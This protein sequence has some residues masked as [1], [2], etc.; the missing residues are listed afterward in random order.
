MSGIL[1]DDRV[2]CIVPK[3]CSPTP[4]RSNCR[5]VVH[6]TLYEPLEL[7]L[8]RNPEI[9]EIVQVLGGMSTTDLLSNGV[10]RAGGVFLTQTSSPRRF[11]VTRIVH[12]HLATHKGVSASKVRMG[13]RDLD[14]VDGGTLREGAHAPHNRFA[15]IGG[16]KRCTGSQIAEGNERFARGHKDGVLGGT[17]SNQG[18][19]D[20]GTDLLC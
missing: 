6:D 17:C 8:N 9:S 14:T 2:R 5:G 18:T 13:V 10:T 1:Y 12:Q 4:Q 11:R 20:H 3:R 7:R 15:S 16:A 19:W